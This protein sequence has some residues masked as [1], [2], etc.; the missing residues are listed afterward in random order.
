[1]VFASLSAVAIALDWPLLITVICTILVGAVPAAVLLGKQRAK[2]SDISTTAK[3]NSIRTVGSKSPKA[4]TAG[5]IALADWGVHPALVRLPYLERDAE[6]EFVSAVESNE[7]VLVVGPSMAGKTRMAVKLLQELF[8]TRQVIVPDVPNGLAVLFATGDVPHEAIIW[9]DDLEGYIAD[10]QNLKTRWIDE[11]KAADNVIVATMRASQYETFQPSVDMPKTQW[12]TLNKFHKVYLLNQSNEQFRL[13]ARVQ[14]PR[15]RQGILDYGLGTYIGGGYIALDRVKLG[16]S[17]NPVGVA[18]VRAAIDWQRSGIGYAIP[19]DILLAALVSYVDLRS[20]APTEEDIASALSW[21]SD[22]SP[23]GG[24]VGLITQEEGSWR[25]FDFLVDQVAAAGTPIPP[26]TWQ[27][28]GSH[29]A[30]PGL[31]NFAGLTAHLHGQR[32]AKEILFRRAAEGGDPEGMANWAKSLDLQ[33]RFDEASDY[34]RKAAGAGSS[35]GMSGLGIAL[36]RSGKN[37][38]AEVQLRHA[39]LLGNADGM[40]N[41]GYLL[42]NQKRVDEGVEWYRKASDAGSAY[43]MTNYGLELAKLGRHKEA[44]VLYRKAADMNSAG[45]LYELSEVYAKRQDHEQSE[46]LCR[47]AVA[48]GNPAAMLKLA[49]VLLARGK[50]EEAEKLHR[51]AA[52]RGGGFLASL[53]SFLAQQDRVSEA[54][55]VLKQAAALGAP[56]AHHCLGVIAARKGELDQ[57]KDHYRTA[58]Q[59]GWVQSMVN[60]AALLLYTEDDEQAME[61]FSRDAVELGSGQGMVLLAILHRKRGDTKEADS[62]LERVK[63][64]DDAAAAMDLYETIAGDVENAI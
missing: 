24:S 18:M 51:R 34:Y 6:A 19:N 35:H 5:Q 36:M 55:P 57:A 60:L 27:L 22:T 26:L 29:G 8:P 10:P 16:A 15:V 12:E 45:G 11:L 38:E 21:A 39:A 58:I 64:T 63:K 31:L 49:D 30:A 17:G 56:Y 53:G 43:G 62:F 61:K 37:D 33:D 20:A 2:Q 50:V 4:P 1:M 13:A 14:A 54:M 44:E 41:L 46:I 9:L 59:D 3:K 25:P 7:P 23:L 42:V 32:D 40:A 28:V 52:G 47:R 48:G